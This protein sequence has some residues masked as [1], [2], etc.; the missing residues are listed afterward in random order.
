M[1]FDMD[2]DGDL[3]LLTTGASAIQLFR[4]DGGRFVDVTASS[5]L[6]PSTQGTGV[7]AVAGDYD[8]DGRADVFL[9][10]DG[11]N[12][13]FHQTASGAFEDVT[14]KTGVPAEAAGARSAAF[15]DVDHDGDLDIVVGGGDG[16][17]QL[18]RNNGNGTFTNIAATAGVAPGRA[19]TIA[20]VPTDF[21]NH[22]D[23][24]MLF[25]G[26]RRAGALPEQARRH[27]PRR[28]AAGR[29]ATE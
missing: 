6:P 27:V 25:V 20:I 18:L 9:L 8:N 21:D 3:D 28:R 23:I 13:L 24:D 11:G 4:N 19:R 16:P 15:V 5:G 12:R 7:A 26:R 10:R 2:G 29:P 17:A 1:L 22:R 14:T